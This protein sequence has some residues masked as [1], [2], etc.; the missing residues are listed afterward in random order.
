MK[1]LA[2]Q[3]FLLIPIVFFAQPNTEVFLFDLNTDNGNF[4]LSNFQN[5]SN[6]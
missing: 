2:I 5:I 6:N 3:L 4:Q 1:R